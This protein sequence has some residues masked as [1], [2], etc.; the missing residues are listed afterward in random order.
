MFI[1]RQEQEKLG[2]TDKDREERYDRQQLWYPDRP[3]KVDNQEGPMDFLGDESFYDPRRLG[4]VRVFPSQITA[5]ATSKLI[6]TYTCGE[7]GLNAGDRVAFYMRG[8][9]PLGCEYRHESDT[10][11]TTDPGTGSELNI[12]RYR[13]QVTAEDTDI[14]LVPFKF[15]F[16]ICRGSLKKGDVVE[17]RVSDPEGFRFTPIADRYEFKTVFRFAGQERGQRLGVPA[18]VEVLP[19][20]PVRLEATRP[21]T[22]KPGEQER[23]HVTMRD[24]FDNRVPYCGFVTAEVLQKTEKTAG[25][26]SGRNV[27]EQLHR[28]P[29]V[30]GMAEFRLNPDAAASP[31]RVYCEEPALETMANPSVISEGRQ[32]YVGDL[33]IHD[34]LS[35]AHQYTDRVYEFAK[36][37]RNMDFISVS[38]QTHGW[39]DNRKW[40][41][42]KY[43]AERWLQEGRFVT[44]LANEWQHT[45]FGDKIIHHAGGDQPFICVD[46][47]RYNTAAKLYDAVRDTGAVVISHH[48][49]YPV[50]S[51]CSRTNFDC[52]DT[53]VERLT[54]LWSM[55][56]SSEGFTPGDRPLR[57]MDPD[58]TVMG[59]LRK[60]LRLGFVAGSDG[61]AGRAGGSAKEPLPYW[62]GQVCVWADELTRAGIMEAL[63][64]RRTYAVTG[65][66]IILK[67][68]VNGAEMGAEIPMTDRAEIRIEAIAPAPIREI[69]LVKNTRLC[70]TFAAGSTGPEYTVAADGCRA[71]IAYD[72]PVTQENTFYHC[73]V[74]LEDGSLAVCSPVWIG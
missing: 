67:M 30:D 50:G 12:G 28:I 17:I 35:E 63:H 11:P 22:V 69:Q 52:V 18:V 13:F 48:S 15:G 16:E 2:S 43:H 26:A 25:P 9:T 14:Q 59:A 73:R 29:M 54:E 47:E 55:H 5:G 64:A 20:A 68:T 51:W 36:N 72:E 10:R 70:K 38:E 24:Q 8:Q 23:V 44:L 19:D 3:C 27:T 1:S 60:G 66:R 62:G 56:G 7:R 4:T 33:H 32:L 49:S 74:V 42:E 71:E 6:F 39:I 45:A 57:G 37:D 41:V 34:N 53:E 65:K 61:H 40:T 58:N 46:D 21:C 31:V